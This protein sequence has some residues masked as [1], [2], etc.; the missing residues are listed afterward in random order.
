[1][2]NPQ[3]SYNWL[4][5]SKQ[6]EDYQ[7]FGESIDLMTRFRRKHISG[8]R[9]CCTKGILELQEEQRLAGINDPKSLAKLSENASKFAL[10]DA[11]T[12]ATNI[13]HEIVE[14]RREEVVDVIDS[15]LDMMAECPDSYLC[16]PKRPISP[17]LSEFI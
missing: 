4:M 5:L 15:V 17:L 8:V 11:V 13:E 6:K 16:P 10:R 12:R 1:M 14:L 2:V 9:R 7:P 3:D